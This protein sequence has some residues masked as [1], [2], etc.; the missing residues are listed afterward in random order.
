MEATVSNLVIPCLKVL[1]TIHLIEV[2][3]HVHDKVLGYYASSSPGF[4]SLI[5]QNK[6][7]DRGRS[8]GKRNTFNKL[9]RLGS[10]KCRVF[11][12]LYKHSIIHSPFNLKKNSP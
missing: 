7:M 5:Q 9:L 4:N 12:L 2:R 10:V 8:K 3:L 1:K 11:C 6:R